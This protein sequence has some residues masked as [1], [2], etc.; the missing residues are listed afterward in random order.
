M[1]VGTAYIAAKEF[2]AR[3]DVMT[4]EKKNLKRWACS[5][6]TETENDGF[7]DIPPPNKQTNPKN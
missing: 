4:A 7:V 2:N 6:I 5:L 3:D 1:Y